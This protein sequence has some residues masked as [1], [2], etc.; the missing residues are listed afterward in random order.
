MLYLKARYDGSF[1]L[2]DHREEMFETGIDLSEN[3]FV[4]ICAPNEEPAWVEIDWSQLLSTADLQV[5][6]FFVFRE[7]GVPHEIAFDIL[8]VLN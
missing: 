6:D 4:L 5:D 1:A 8:A 7:A 3:F 2:E